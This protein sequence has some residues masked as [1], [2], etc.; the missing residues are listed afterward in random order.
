L[1]RIG[2]PGAPAILLIR[3]FG[4]QMCQWPDPYLEGLARELQVVTFDNRDV[5]LSQKFAEAGEPA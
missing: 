4:T 3:G 5:G 1:A 2:E